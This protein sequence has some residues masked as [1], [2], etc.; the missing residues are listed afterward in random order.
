MAMLLKNFRKEMKK[1]RNKPSNKVAQAVGRNW[2]NILNTGELVVERYSE[3]V[4]GKVKIY[5][6]IPRYKTICV[7]QLCE[8]T[9]ENVKEACIRHF[10]RQFQLGTNVAC[11]VLAGDQGPS[12]VSMSQIPDLRLIHFRFI[13]AVGDNSPKVRDYDSF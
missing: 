10:T 3:E 2:R 4:T 8:L 12:C 13:K 9:I 1:K 6:R 11:D 5:A 7:L